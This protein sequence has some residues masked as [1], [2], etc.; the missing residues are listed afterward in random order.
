M[1]I[2]VFLRY[3]IQLAS[4]S[5]PLIPVSAIIPTRNR[6]ST[7]LNTFISLAAQSVQPTE[8]VVVDASNNHFTKEV[9]DKRIKGLISNVY[10]HRAIIAGA[11]AQR[12]QGV[13][14]ATQEYICFMDDDILLEPLCLEK[15]WQA[16]TNDAKVGGVNAMIT[17]QLYTTPGRI[18]KALF[19]LLSGKKEA[20]YAGKCIG[21]ALNLLPEDRNDLPEVVP[22]EWL[23]TTCVLYRKLAL[24]I[25]PFPPIFEGYSLMEDLTLALNVGKKWKLAN[26]RTA[27]IFHD[28][29]PGSHKK[30]LA[31][32]AKMELVNRHYVMT[33]VLDR[34]GVKYILKL[35]L[36]QVF[37]IVTSLTKTNGWLTLPQVLKGKVAGI[38]EIIYGKKGN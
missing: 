18:S 38:Y 30:D 13:A 35:A 20:S 32:L 21:P 15:L 1:Y 2:F 26:V 24:P 22:V 12:N 9:C 19:R 4:F 27:R 33:H 6:S 3:T 16:I 36:L 28:S 34:R 14:L 5:K 8:I 10:Y 25:P 17:N 23:N 7:L 31:Q 11:A 29:Q 37:G